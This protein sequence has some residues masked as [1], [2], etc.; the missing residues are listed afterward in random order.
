MKNLTDIDKLTKDTRRY[1]FADGL[2]DITYGIIFLALGL[3]CWFFFSYT[4]LRLFITALIVNREITILGMVLIFSLFILLAFGSQRI[5]QRIRQAKL[6]K[7]SGFV[8]PLRMQVRWPIQLIAAAISITSIVTAFGLML[9]GHLTKEAVLQ[10]LVFSAGL[11]TSITFIGLGIDLKIRRY[12]SVGVCGMV[13]SIVILLL[14]LSFSTSWLLWGIS[15]MVVL[16]ISGIWALRRYQVPTR[17]S[18]DE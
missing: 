9:K 4:G 15:W 3:L 10:T 11:A 12:L 1:E 8:K 13:I 5:A 7:K 2:V 17:R 18:A 14:Q 16:A 6:W